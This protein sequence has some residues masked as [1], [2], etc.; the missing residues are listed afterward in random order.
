MTKEQQGGK[1]HVQEGYQPRTSERGYRPQGDGTKPPATAT[2]PTGGTGVS[3][4]SRSGSGGNT[5][6]G[7]GESS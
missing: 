2:P 7:Q 3:G 4:A 6:G 5:V 1:E